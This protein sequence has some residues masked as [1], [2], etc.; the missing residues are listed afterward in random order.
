MSGNFVRFGDCRAFVDSFYITPTY[1]GL[2]CGVPDREMNLRIIATAKSRLEGLWGDRDCIHV[3][4]AAITT[5]KKDMILYDDLP[6]HIQNDIKE[7]ERLPPV[8]CMVWLTSWTPIKD[9]SM[10]GSHSFVIFY[11][12]EEML[13]LPIAK[14]V[15]AACSGLS[16]KQIAEDFDI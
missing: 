5:L 2:I 11:Q 12:S 6:K 9:K 13:E 3:I 16:W 1:A 4:G 7:G 10:C 15:E 8:E 14:Q